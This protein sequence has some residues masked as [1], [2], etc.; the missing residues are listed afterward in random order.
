MNG[1]FSFEVSSYGGMDRRLSGQIPSYGVGAGAARCPNRAA[2]ETLLGR[3][4]Y[5]QRLSPHLHLPRSPEITMNSSHSL[6]ADLVDYAGLFPPAKLP[7][8]PAVAN[9]A[10]YRQGP[11][12]SMLGRFVVPAARLEELERAAASHLPG[13]GEA[14]WELSV[15]GGTD[16]PG[17]AAALAA[18]H[19]RH[20]EGG[21]R[22]TAVEMKAATAEEIEGILAALP[23][24]VE[25]F[26]EIDH[27]QDPAPLIRALA[28]TRGRAKIRTGGVT[29]DAFPTPEEVARFMEACHAAGVPFK[30][31]AGL[32]HP[33][34]GP[35]RLTY[36]EGSPEGVMFGFLNVF[37]GAAL[38]RAGKIEG[39]ELL[40]LL[41]E[42]DPAQF[43]LGEDAVAWRGKK[44]SAAEV[45]AARQGFARSYGSCSFAEPVEDLQALSWL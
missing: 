43:T 24:E 38:L 29:E 37:V 15:L 19:G 9:Y 27:R 20:P 34:R 22:A 1:S 25:P 31:T 28:G 39:E 17:T 42:R 13:P 4:R 45:A 33:L 41:Q 18:L 11:H 44:L 7:M 35:Y 21:L 32:H 30:A 23:E 10:A 36:D 8:E 5:N 3:G 26:F 2:S 6:L 14:P 40:E 12:A 16:G